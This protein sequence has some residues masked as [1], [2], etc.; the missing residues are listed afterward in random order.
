MRIKSRL[1][2]YYDYVEKI[3]GGDP[4]IPYN[5]EVIHNPVEDKKQCALAGRY[6]EGGGGF[7][8]PKDT[9]SPGLPR[10]T[11]HWERRNLKGKIKHYRGL[12]VVGKLYYLYQE[13]EIQD[14]EPPE[15][16][17]KEVVTLPWMILA[18]FK[19]GTLTEESGK[20]FP[21]LEKIHK[22]LKA[23]VFLFDDD[24]HRNTII[25]H[26]VPVMADF[27]MAAMVPAEQMYQELAMFMGKLYAENPDMQP[28]SPRTDVE[29]IESHGFDKKQS[30][31]HRK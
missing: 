1:K 18:Q 9:Q 6:F 11:D 30:F 21:A 23:P 5:R 16:L 10:G 28:A 17:Q 3:Y 14:P 22:Y 7:I 19:W 26:R 31:R 25:H 27:G 4:N 24:N 8:L 12:S 29:K 2:D 13:S 20:F 15:I